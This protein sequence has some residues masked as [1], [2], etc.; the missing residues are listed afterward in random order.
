MR[1]PGMVCRGLSAGIFILILV[2]GLV[3]PVSAGDTGTYRIEDYVVTLDPQNDGRVRISYEQEWNV[4][5]GNIPW[6]TVGL[7]NS[8]FVIEDFGGAA[9]EASPVSGGGFTGIRLDLDR[10]YQAGE[11][12]R[13]SFTV[14]QGNL[15]ERLPEEERWRI[16]FTPGWYDNA[17]TGRLEINL[18]S[19]VDIQTYDVIEPAPASSGENRITWVRTGLAPGERFNIRVESLDGRFLTEEEPGQ[20]QEGGAWSP[21]IFIIIGIIVV[22]GILIYWA[23]WRSRK[24][25]EASL[26]RRIAETEREMALNRE[27]EKR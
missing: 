23:I 3:I 10:G 24:E 19:P 12:F 15:L 27:K 1:I 11:S 2:M 14:L 18:N 9:I 21:T 16:N 5:S 26:Q 6:I 25:R 8:N 22:I 13:V 7:A 20:A 17:E 4:F